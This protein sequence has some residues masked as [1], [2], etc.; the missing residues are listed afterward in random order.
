VAAVASA[1]RGF[2]LAGQVA[3]PSSLACGAGARVN[4]GPG[5]GGPAL[6]S[7]L[8]AGGW[9]AA[10]KYLY[11]AEKRDHINDRERRKR[12]RVADGSP[13]CHRVVVVVYSS[14]YPPLP[15]YMGWASNPTLNRLPIPYLHLDNAADKLLTVGPHPEVD[16][17]IPNLSPTRATGGETPRRIHVT[18]L[19]P[20]PKVHLLST[21]EFPAPFP[22]LP[23]RD[24]NFPS[25]AGSGT[26]AISG[27]QIYS[28]GA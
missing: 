28:L 26:H 2:G 13:A 14:L 25:R 3:L 20:R 16:A 9:C 12:D 1:Q 18:P 6:P 7:S 10:R 4:G 8:A 24:R 27:L 22:A 11:A 21:S 5:A 19:C 17:A 15:V 23:I